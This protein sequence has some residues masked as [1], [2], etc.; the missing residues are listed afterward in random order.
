M[1]FLKYSLITVLTLM[2]LGCAGYLIASSG[3]Q[4]KPGYAK[5]D[6]PSWLSTETTV[7]LNIGPR[8][9]KPVRWVIK[10]LISTSDHQL[11]L[12][13]RLILTVMLDLQGLQLRIY[14]VDDNRPVFDQA[15]DDAIIS[16]KQGHWQTLL[17]V[18]EDDKRMV[19]MQAGDQGMISGLTILASTPENAFFVNLIGHLTPESIAIIADSLAASNQTNL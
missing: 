14:E 5:I 8:G 19:V 7:A 18:R 12:S 13:E 6:L 15:I 1:T 9:L 11:D 10:R 2:L 3:V 17:S 16:L 4:S